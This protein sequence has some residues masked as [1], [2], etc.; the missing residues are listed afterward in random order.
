M[1]MQAWI[2]ETWAK[3]NDANKKQ[4]EDFMQF[5]LLKQ[6]DD[7]KLRK[8]R[9]QFDVMKGQIELYDNFDD[10]MPGLEEYV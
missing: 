4:A 3:L 1:A 2:P 7:P 8:T 9:L 6:E 10:P 5:L